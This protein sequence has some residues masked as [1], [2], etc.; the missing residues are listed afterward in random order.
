MMSKKNLQHQWGASGSKKQAVMLLIV[1]LVGHFGARNALR[2]NLLEVSKYFEV[3]G[4]FCTI[5]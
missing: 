5:T 4:S 2:H 1:P 3:G